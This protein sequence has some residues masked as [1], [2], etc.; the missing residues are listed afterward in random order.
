LVINTGLISIQGNFSSHRQKIS[1]VFPHTK[2]FMIR[3][4]SD[5]PDKLDLVIIP[6]GESSTIH[7]LADLSG[8]HNKLKDLSG[9]GVFFLA[10]CAG[11]IL[12]SRKIINPGLAKPW[13]FIDITTQ[14]NAYGRQVDSTI[15]NIN[16]TGSARKYIPDRQCEGVFIR[17]P[18]IVQ[19]GSEVEILAV[20]NQEPV[21][22]KQDNILA[23]TFH[24]EL[25]SF[26]PVYNILK[27]IMQAV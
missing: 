18:K 23:A 9:K 12:L 8:L 22:V 3:D 21:L 7:M 1:E 6:G 4:I 14:R 11:A 25:S 20:C 17:A 16:F 2:I 5:L 26:S 15:Q 19:L 13:K 24:P 27:N 10:T